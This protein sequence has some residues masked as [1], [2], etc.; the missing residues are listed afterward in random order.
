[1]ITSYLIPILFI[2]NICNNQQIQIDTWNYKISEH[3]FENITTFLKNKKRTENQ[4]KV[5]DTIT[6]WQFYK[7][8]ELLF[9]SNLFDSN[10]F[11]AKI[12]TSDKYENLI[13]NMFYDFNSEVMTRKIELVYENKILARFFDENQSHLPFKIPKS[14]IDKISKENIGKDIY[15]N[16]FDKINKNGMTIGILKLARE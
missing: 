7:D 15:I 8:T 6:N 3:K 1:M 4:I 12:K 10:R 5:V 2:V 14:E 9:R 13:L 16:Y 11:T